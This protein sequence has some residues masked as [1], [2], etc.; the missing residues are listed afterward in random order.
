M[1]AHRGFSLVEIIVAISIIALLGAIAIPNLRNLSK[2][3]EIDS[4]AL[5]VLNTLKTAQSSASSRIRCSNDEASDSWTVRLAPGNYSLIAGCQT[6]GNQTIFTRVYAP[7]STAT[8]AAYSG[9]SNVC[10]GSTVDIIFSRSQ[11][12]YLC[13]GSVTPQTGSVNLTLSNS[14]ET[15]TK[16]V[17]I[18]QG[19]V[20]K[21]E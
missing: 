5:Q 9:N 10:S 20:I 11:I 1:T 8:A 21:I 7:A 13:S 12:Y 14:T 6:S 18:D 17:K 3:Q 16:V 4:A 15:L 19:G 2:E